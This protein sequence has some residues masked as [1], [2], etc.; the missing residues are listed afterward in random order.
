MPTGGSDW[1]VRSETVLE[2]FRLPLL[3]TSRS[4]LSKLTK[5]VHTIRVDSD[6]VHSPFPIIIK[7]GHLTDESTW[8]VLIKK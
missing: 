1:D 8:L 4:P 6:A 7:P 2:G 5:L 3:D